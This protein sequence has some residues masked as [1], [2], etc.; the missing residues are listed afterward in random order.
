MVNGSACSPSL[1]AGWGSLPSH[2]DLPMGKLGLGT[3]RG[4]AT[5]G[6]TGDR[7]FYVACLPPS[8]SLS[9]SD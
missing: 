2:P 3:G 9:S 5:S 1:C 4:D 8:Y 6:Q 7:M